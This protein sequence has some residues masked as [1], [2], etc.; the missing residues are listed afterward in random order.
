MVLPLPVPADPEEDAVRFI[1]LERYPIFFIDMM[2]GYPTLASD[3]PDTLD[4]D[5][6]PLVVH[7]VG[8]F[9]A[10]FVPKFNDFDRLDERFR[11]STEVWSKLPAYND[12]GF[13][14]F[15]LKGGS[16]LRTV[17]PMAFEFP[18][19]NP[20]LLYFPT[21]HIHDGQL[22]S[23]AHFDHMLICQVTPELVGYVDGWR[24][25]DDKASAFMDL[26]R[27]D[28]IVD[29]NARCWYRGLTG[30][31]ENKDTLVGVNGSVP[32]AV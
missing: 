23:D 5:F 7:D 3:I 32:K 25:S 21:I 6:S 2:V 19:R 11:I 16:Q 28:C 8:D 22:H 30:R 24:P 4:L 26:S 15:K 9:E 20:N 29:G 31:L 10:S 1:N 27:S 17:H 18:C 13:A 12:F 14:V